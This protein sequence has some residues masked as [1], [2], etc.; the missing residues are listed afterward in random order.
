M[1]PTYEQIAKDLGLELPKSFLSI[2][3]YLKPYDILSQVFIWQAVN[4][5]KHGDKE[6][7]QK[8]R[9]TFL[10][11]QGQAFDRILEAK[12]DPNVSYR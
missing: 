2:E 5:N 6:Q 3:D 12:N 10:L 11:I 9:E 4:C 7:T 8:L 1:Q